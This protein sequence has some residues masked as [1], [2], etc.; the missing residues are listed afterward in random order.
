MASLV[1]LLVLILFVPS[2]LWSA[3]VLSILWGWFMTPIFG[4]PSLSIAAAIGVR[5]V[6]SFTTYQYSKR[7]ETTTPSEQLDRVIFQLVSPALVLLIGY[8]AKQWM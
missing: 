8:I 1:H 5:L 7:D 4:L 3:Y 2:M 6:I